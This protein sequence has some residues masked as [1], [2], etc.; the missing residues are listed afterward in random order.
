MTFFKTIFTEKLAAMRAAAPRATLHM[1]HESNGFSLYLDEAAAARKL[2]QLGALT[3]HAEDILEDSVPILFI[4][5]EQTIKF[6]EEV[7][8]VHSVAFVDVTLANRVN[9][10]RHTMYAY[11]PRQVVVPLN[12][13]YAAPW[14]EKP[15]INAHIVEIDGTVTSFTQPLVKTADDDFWG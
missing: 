9:N 6:V 7:T 5:L 10:A 15:V 4:P 3:D 13:H 1:L 11:F 14:V 2:S 8:A 12:E